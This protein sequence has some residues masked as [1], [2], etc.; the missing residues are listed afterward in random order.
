VSVILAVVVCRDR[1]VEDVVGVLDEKV[2][3]EREFEEG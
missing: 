2:V 1:E 3:E